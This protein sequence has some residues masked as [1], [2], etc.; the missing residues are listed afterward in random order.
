MKLG[1]GL[2]QSILNTDY[3]RFAKQAGATHIVAHLSGYLGGNSARPPAAG[4][5]DWQFSGPD[6]YAWS[7]EGMRDLRAAIQA[8]GLELEAIENFAPH[9]WSDVL[10]DGPRKREQMEN[11]KQ[12]DLPARILFYTDGVRLACQG[13]PVIEPLKSMQSKGVELVLCKTC[14]DAFHLADQVEVGVVGGMPDILDSL[15][16]AS[17]VVSL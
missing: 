3:F 8:E 10:L 1:L 7:Y 6:D 4:S 11:L 9:L 15:Q 16:K 5:E 13:S 2:Y 17:K 12:I 14:L